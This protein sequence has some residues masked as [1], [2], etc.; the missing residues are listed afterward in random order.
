LIDEYTRECLTIRVA[1][2]INTFG[3]IETFAD[4]MLEHGIL[5]HIRSDS[6]PEITA[7][8]VGDWLA[9]IGSKTLLIE[10]G[11]PWENDYCESLTASFAT[12][13]STARSFAI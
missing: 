12:S 5:A 4:A 10:P 2:R 7:R 1:R 8:V 9:Q 13:C 11:S 6:G 3:V